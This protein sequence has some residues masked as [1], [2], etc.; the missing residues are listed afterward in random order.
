MRPNVNF[1]V[2]FNVKTLLTLFSQVISKNRRMNVS[3]S[4]ESLTEMPLK[5]NT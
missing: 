5:F 1:K 3:V 2:N 4:V